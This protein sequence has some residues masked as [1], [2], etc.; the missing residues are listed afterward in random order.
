VVWLALLAALAV[1]ALG[2]MFSQTLRE[3]TAGTAHQMI[4]RVLAPLA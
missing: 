4:D 3:R 2:A 1:A